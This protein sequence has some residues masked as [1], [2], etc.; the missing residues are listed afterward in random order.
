MKKIKIIDKETNIRQKLVS[1]KNAPLATYKKLTVGDVSFPKFIR[2]ELYTSLFGSLPGGVGYFLRKKFYP[3][4]IGKIGKGVIIGRGVVIRHPEKLIIGDNVT[5]DDNCLI[6]ARGAA[7]GEGFVI[8]DHVLINRNC[9]LIAKNGAIR[10]GA[11]SSLGSNNVIVSMDGVRIGKSV[12][13]AGGCY[14]STGNYEFNDPDMPVMDQNLYTSG[15]VTIGD[16]AWIGTRATILDGVRIGA[17]SII[18]AGALVNDDI[19]DKSIAVGIPAKIIR[20]R[21]RGRS[22]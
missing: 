9:M 22:A 1:G 4:F 2:Y 11:H 16:G 3:G 7:D 18:G 21:T 13:T 15:P 5:I 10:I 20:Q 8:E 14:I 17:N 12:L 19:P 6:D